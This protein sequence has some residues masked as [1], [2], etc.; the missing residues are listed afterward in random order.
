[1]EAQLKEQ[2]EE[3][4]TAIG[5]WQQSYT[6]LEEKNS[7]L[8][9]LVEVSREESKNLREQEV[10]SLE[11]KLVEAEAA[12]AAATERSSGTDEAAMRLKGRWLVSW[13]HKLSLSLTYSVL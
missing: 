3:A 10:A 8:E 6:A 4:S 7:E 5:V 13:G 2:E 9:Q 11:R 1:M 12:L